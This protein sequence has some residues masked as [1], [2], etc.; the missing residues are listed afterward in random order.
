MKK[1]E[2]AFF[3]K[4]KPSMFK[5]KTDKVFTLAFSIGQVCHFAS[6]LDVNLTR[7]VTPFPAPSACDTAWLPLSCNKSGEQLIF[8]C[9]CIFVQDLLN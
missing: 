6:A 5:K 2:D 4:K 9:C 7:D 3:L 8:A 1:K